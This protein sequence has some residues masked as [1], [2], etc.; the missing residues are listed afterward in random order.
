VTEPVERWSRGRKSLTCGVELE[1]AEVRASFQTFTGRRT[2]TYRVDHVEVTTHWEVGLEEE[3]RTL[4][5]LEC[6]E[7]LDGKPTS[8]GALLRPGDLDETP[9]WLES[10]I[11]RASPRDVG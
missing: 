10:I 11:T 1:G 9:A 6:M 4:V 8:Q 5:R 3:G 2:A 7:V